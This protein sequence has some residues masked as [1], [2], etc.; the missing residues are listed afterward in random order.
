MVM[1]VDDLNLF[2]R[3]VEWRDFVHTVTNFRAAK[4]LEEVLSN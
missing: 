3:S 4:H 1:L 2:L